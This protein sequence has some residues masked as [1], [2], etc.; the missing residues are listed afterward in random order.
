VRNGKE[1]RGRFDGVVNTVSASTRTLVLTLIGVLGLM[2][3]G[4][5]QLTK[6]PYKYLYLNTNAKI[7][8]FVET[9]AEVCE[10]HAKDW[11]AGCPGTTCSCC[12]GDSYKITVASPN[13]PGAV[14]PY[15]ALRQ[16]FCDEGPVGPYMNSPPGD[17]CPIPI[18]TD[19][20]PVCIGN[21]VDPSTG[22]KVQIDTDFHCCPVKLKGDLL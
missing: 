4:Y 18:A 13:C 7:L 1:N 10:T 12:D 22:D 20:P 16:Y 9:A 15:T 21:P 2:S 19:K 6:L 3:P 11:S 14:H 17:G 5:A 8:G